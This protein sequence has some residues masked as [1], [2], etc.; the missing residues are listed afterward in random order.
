MVETPSDGEISVDFVVKD[1]ECEEASVDKQWTD[2]DWSW[3]A[4]WSRIPVIT[5]GQW[6]KYETNNSCWLML[7]SL[8]YFIREAVENEY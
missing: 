5:Y 4:D 7:L 8:W 1:K 6:H 2:S 3:T